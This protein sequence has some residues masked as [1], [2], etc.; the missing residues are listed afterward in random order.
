MVDW[1]LARVGEEVLS[2]EFTLR[3]DG[4]KGLSTGKGDGGR[5]L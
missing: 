4:E 3:M 2:T 1:R 5:T